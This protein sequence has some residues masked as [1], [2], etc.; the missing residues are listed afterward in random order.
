MTKEITVKGA[1]QGVG[2]R[3]FIAEKAAGYNLGGYVKN[4]GAEVR[5]VVTGS[6]CDITAFLSCIKNE[7][8]PGAFIL[9]ISCKETTIDVIPD[10]YRQDPGAF[11]IID[12]TELDLSSEIPVFLP[13]IG[14]CDDCMSE[15]LD[16]GD[17]RYRYP[18]ISCAVCGPRLSIL[19]S[20]P[21]DRPTTTMKDFVMCPSCASEY[22][23]GRRRYAQTISCHDC[24]PQM[25]LRRYIRSD[26]ADESKDFIDS[27]PSES[28][29]EAAKIL[30]EG[31]IIALKGVSGYQL[32]CRPEKEA[33]ARL[34]QI[35]GREK[36]PFAI[37]FSDIDSVRAYAFVS[38]ME[39]EILKSS[40]RPIVLLKKK[41]EFD[42]EVIKNSRYIGA[43]LPS[44]GVHRLLIDEVG[45][46]IVTSCNLSDQPII[47]GDEEL[48][49]SSIISQIDGVLYHKRVI[50]MP[51]D[52]SVMFVISDG[53]RE[54]QQFIRRA[55]GFA[56]LP[57][58]ID[59]NTLIDDC[60]DR[61]SSFDT[62]KVV[63]SNSGDV[64]ESSFDRK[65]V[66]LSYG[67]D[68][69]SCFAFGHADRIMPSQYIGDLENYDTNMC[70]RQIL[71]DY[72]RLFG[73]APN[74]LVCDLHPSYF[75][76][77]F[78]RE[79]AAEKG[80]RLIELAHHAAH[81]YSVM[82]ENSLKSC[83]GVS[84]DGTGYGTDGNIWGGEFISVKGADW[85]REGHLSYVL[86]PGGD[87][88]SKDAGRVR[89]GYAYQ[90]GLSGAL[91]LTDD[92]KM[93]PLIQK[94]LE[95]RIGTY[96]SSSMGRLFDAISS[97]LG[98]CDYNSYE[99][100][101]AIR[102][103][104]AAWEYIDEKMPGKD[105]QIAEML[106]ERVN[107]YE[108]IPEL[109][110]YVYDLR[111]H[112]SDNSPAGIVV[113]QA[114]MFRDVFGLLQSG[115]YTVQAISLGFHRAVLAMIR[116]VCML[117]RN[118]SGENSV[119]LSGGVFNNRI[120]LTGAIKAL[121]DS[122]FIVYRNSKLPLGD[123]CI[124]T[125]QAYYGMLSDI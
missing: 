25:I 11:H 29:K 107:S 97:L 71:D 95:N 6:E 4:M 103:E 39:E 1:V 58:I 79:D 12:S 76:S 30:L 57:V 45:P 122:G 24:G 124:S 41:Y 21:Y 113:D 42:E 116:D 90:T 55:R 63:L 47:I 121:E 20:L 82:A 111:S 78:A 59:K 77:G 80:I 28:V 51:Q 102:L 9:S 120:L 50:N 36:K 94:A 40:A 72:K 56:P 105:R 119:C 37:M 15:M 49:E 13:D 2:Y 87:S 7:M 88:T 34:R 86:L 8:P 54:Y 106:T 100:E 73:Q 18:L 68:L 89:A 43:F 123:G 118:S 52:D 110:F 46:L 16:A 33:A 108:D 75:S 5:I 109:S 114:G 26:E 101:C 91:E 98:I 10:E 104:N 17:R 115:R 60:E 112:D 67:G 69:K 61:K 27:E 96:E 92:D 65:K 84:F 66:V 125:G 23:K 53:K 62:K 31:G 32:V 38:P 81:I 74:L 85:K 70:Y 22:S 14:I 83:I 99:G 19:S 117:I 44:A 48:F 35:K 64:K 3:P 93:L